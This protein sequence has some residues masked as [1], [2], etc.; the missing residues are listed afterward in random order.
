ML[1]HF[2][3]P[4]SVDYRLQDEKAVEGPSVFAGAMT[5]QALERAARQGH[6]ALPFV[7]SVYFVVKASAPLRLRV[8]KES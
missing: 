8:E 7:Y 5:K 1:C 2:A 3:R 6:H 4:A